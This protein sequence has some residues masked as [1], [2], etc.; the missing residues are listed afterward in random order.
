[1][2]WTDR[3][4]AA[5]S[6]ASPPPTEP[7]SPFSGLAQ[8]IRYAARLLRRQ[9]RHALLTIATL[10]LGIGATTV[11]FSVTYGVLMKPLPWPRSDRIVLLKETRG[12][13]VPRFGAFTNTAYLAWREHAA[14][15]D[16]IAAWSQS[17]V[18][19]T[20]TGD[21]ERIRIAT[22]TSS[23]FPGARCAPSDRLILRA[24]R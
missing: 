22:A 19:L 2:E 17:R 24:E 11:L 21:P 10:A 3:I 6:G 13:S 20:G 5:F 4:R 1:M 15:I 7:P 9:P 8:D 14:T 23:L 12:G 16:G 18:T